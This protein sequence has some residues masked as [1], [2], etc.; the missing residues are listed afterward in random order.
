[1]GSVKSRDTA[2]F[3]PLP[4]RGKTFRFRRLQK[5]HLQRQAVRKT[6]S[7][8]PRRQ[9]ATGITIKTEQIGCEC[10]HSGTIVTVF[11]DLENLTKRYTWGMLTPQKIKTGNIAH[12]IRTARSV[13][14]SV[15]CHFD[16]R[17]QLGESRCHELEDILTA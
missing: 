8:I 9:T 12:N 10:P 5:R 15:L 6:A 3:M 16:A 11:G 17:Q 7:P 13:L 4:A 2:T 1:M 14:E